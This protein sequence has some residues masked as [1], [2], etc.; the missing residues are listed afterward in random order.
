MFLQAVI[1]GESSIW[2]YC[3]HGE[4]NSEINL[5]SV[6]SCIIAV[7]LLLVAKMAIHKLLYWTA[8]AVNTRGETVCHLLDSFSNYGLIILG[9]FICLNRLGVNARTLSLTGGVAGVVFGIGC[10]NIV[11]DILA[12]ILMTFEGIAHVGDLVLLEGQYGIVLSIGVRMTR[13]KWY[14][15]VTSIR[16]NDFKNFV[17]IPRDGM[18]RVTTDLTI[19]MDMSLK[20]TE[21]ILLQALPRMHESL[22]EEL[23]DEIEGPLY[24]GPEQITDN[25][26]MLKFA[27]FC[28][29]ENFRKAAF[30]LNRRL[31]LMC[32]EHGI[33]IALPQVVVHRGPQE[34]P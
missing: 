31:K 5:Y 11:A 4:W 1:T 14:G 24:L 17:Y 27:L 32:E 9:I 33:R 29:G 34:E 25:G 28:K 18:I 12:G 3:M 8:R 13:L 6:T 10:Q 22:Q 7:C 15:V 21:E 20:E 19:A 2:Y 23:D 16:N 26:V 30:G